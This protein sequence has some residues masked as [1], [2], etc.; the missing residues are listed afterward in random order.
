VFD[1]FVVVVSVLA[2]ATVLLTCA[3]VSF[4]AAWATVFVWLA[5][6]I[7]EPLCVSTNAAAPMML[8]IASAPTTMG[9]DALVDFIAQ[10]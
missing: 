6:C 8:A 9:V 10:A 2:A 3:A 1:V 5:L 7:F 4:V